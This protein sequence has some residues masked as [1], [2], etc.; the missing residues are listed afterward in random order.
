MAS[1]SYKDPT[2]GNWVE[3]P[4]GGIDEEFLKNNVALLQNAT[5][6]ADGTDLNTLLTSGTYVYQGTNI[7]NSPITNVRKGF[8]LNVIK[9]SSNGQVIQIMYSI[10]GATDLS[11][12]GI[13]YR[14]TT[15]IGSTSIT[16]RWKQLVTTTTFASET[17]AGVSKI[18][19]DS[20]NY[21]C[22]DTQ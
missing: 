18:Y 6:L 16:D 13:F 19:V 22:I 1:I 12:G 4:T 2:S 17:Q 8:I 20:D 5:V 14:R 9:L 11:E 15:A 21:L 7:V 10:T 3:I